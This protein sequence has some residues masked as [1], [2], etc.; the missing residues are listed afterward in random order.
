M[1]T[2]RARMYAERPL[3]FCEEPLDT[4]RSLRQPYFAEVARGRGCLSLDRPK[5][6]QTNTREGVT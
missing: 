5:Q 4:H 1:G 3:A 2:S 6:T